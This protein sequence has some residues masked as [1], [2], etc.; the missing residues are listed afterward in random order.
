MG[1]FSSP[2][3]TYSQQERSLTTKEILEIVSRR[4]VGTLTQH[5]EALVEQALVAKKGRDG[6]ISLRQI[7]DA[8]DHLENKNQIS[9]N[10]KK[11]LVALFEERLTT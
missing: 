6:K 10:D 7:Y 11:K 1:L 4:T 8:L 3:N 9:T 2:R 5:E